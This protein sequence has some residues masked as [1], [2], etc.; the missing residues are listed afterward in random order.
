MLIDERRSKLSKLINTEWIYSMY[1]P[2]YGYDEKA[3]EDAEKEMK[4]AIKRIC[5]LQK[6]I[7][8]IKESK[9]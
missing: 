8:I 9:I 1:W 5:D 7:D 6:A 4:F 2:D 3:L